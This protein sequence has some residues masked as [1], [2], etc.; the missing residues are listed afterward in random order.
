M[1]ANS[2]ICYG[3]SCNYSAVFDSQ[4]PFPTCIP[5]MQNGVRAQCRPAAPLGLGSTGNPQGECSR[6]WPTEPIPLPP[7]R[8]W[9]RPGEQK[10][11]HACT[12]T[13]EPGPTSAGT[14]SRHRHS[15]GWRHTSGDAQSSEMGLWDH[16]G[17]ER[18]Q[19]GQG[20]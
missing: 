13:L 1:N 5:F 10:R 11:A 3:I 8:E 4:H 14:M 18:S 7:A 19:T 15:Q 6:T 2:M 12:S 17:Q 16:V 20:N 9:G